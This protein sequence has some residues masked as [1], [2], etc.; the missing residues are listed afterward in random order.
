MNHSQSQ[1][2]V[3]AG[4]GNRAV[5]LLLDV[6]LLVF[7]AATVSGPAEA[8]KPY[9]LPGLCL[10]Y[11]AAM[12]L[13]PLQGT[14]GKWI[15]R[16]KMCDRQGQR[17]RW[18]A[19]LLRT[20]ATIAW[21]SL[22]LLFGMAAAVSVS[23]K[24]TLM[25]AWWLLFLVPWMPM[26]FMSHHESAFDLLAGTRV[27]RYQTDP[28]RIAGAETTEKRKLLNGIVLV[29]GCLLIGY[30]LST[31]IHVMKVK[32]VHGRIAYAIGE[33]L[34]LRK[35]IEAFHDA[36]KRW[37]TTLD[38]GI[39]DWT[40]YPDG[41]SYRLQENGSVVITFSVLPEL[42]GQRITFVPL[43]TENGQLDW[44]CHADAGLE[45]SYLPGSCR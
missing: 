16:I 38:L 35:T 19:S 6:I 20:T 13:T 45:R 1:P 8:F 9:V 28:E 7:L 11:F 15:C 32:S 2:P 12:P 40:P 10:A 26:G 41:G 29:L 4:D 3:I 24:Q 22:P 31:S 18:R 33:T 36:E 43:L 42:K 39:P 30:I 5:A 23:I 27:V 44:Q 25:E 14:L 37:P 34:P 21:F 17:L